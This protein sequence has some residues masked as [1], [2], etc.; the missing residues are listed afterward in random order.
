MEASGFM[1]IFPLQIRFDDFYTKNEV[2]VLNRRDFL[3][4]CFTL[5]A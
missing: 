3:L 4:S 1:L 5:S 2:D